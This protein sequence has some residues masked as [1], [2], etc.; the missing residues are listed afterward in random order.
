MPLSDAV[1]IILIG[2]AIGWLIV[3]ALNWKRIARLENSVTFLKE[4]N[5]R[6]LNENRE[7]RFGARPRILRKPTRP[8]A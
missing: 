1:G 4:A 6:L 7:L 5:K 3:L 8:P 2:I